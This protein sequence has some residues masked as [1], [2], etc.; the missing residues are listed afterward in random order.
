[1]AVMFTIAVSPALSML[2][3]LFW[4]GMILIMLLI[5]LLV[6]INPIIIAQY[7]FTK[8][9]EVLN[10]IKS[11]F[12]IGCGSIYVFA[13]PY[14]ISMGIFILALLLVGVAGAI[15][16]GWIYGG[17]LLIVFLLTL[18]WSRI[19]IYKIIKNAENKK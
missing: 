5:V 16:S 17:A 3:A 4:T 12:K 13:I 19:Y 11:M 7:N 18:S 1:M 8:K 2:E 15:L 14:I 9:K 6:M 10:S